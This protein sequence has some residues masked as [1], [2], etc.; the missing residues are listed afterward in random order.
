MEYDKINNLL[1][2]EDNE[3]EQLSKFVTREYVRV[4]S[5]L[6]TFNK[7]K[8]IRFKTPMLRSNLCDYSDAYILVNGTITVTGNHPRDRQNRPMILKNNAPFISSITRINGELIEDANDLDIVMPMYNLLEYSENYRKTTGSLYNYY[9]DELSDDNDNDDFGN[10]KVVNS[11]FF[12]I[13]RI[14]YCIIYFINNKY[15]FTPIRSISFS[16]YIFEFRYS[17]SITYFKSTIFFIMFINIYSFI[18][19]FNIS[20]FHF[21]CTMFSIIYLRTTSSTTS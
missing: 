5:L 1:L 11:K 17:N 4:N 12:N 15:F 21:N 20:W 9:R 16:K 10:I 18:I 14:W 3:S 13:I 6:N 19:I 8:S 7:N 2:S